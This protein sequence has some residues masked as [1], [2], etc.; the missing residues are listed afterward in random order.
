MNVSFCK[1]R[2]GA[3]LS[4][5]T[6]L[7]KFAVLVLVFVSAV[8]SLYAETTLKW[9][10]YSQDERISSY[11]WQLG[12]EEDG[13]W[14]VVDSSVTTLILASPESDVLYVQASY[15][16][17]NWSLSS[18][19]SHSEVKSGQSFSLR[20]SLSPYSLAL[21]R[22]YNGYGTSSS[23]TKTDSVYGLSS[24]FEFDWAPTSWLT[25]YPE[26]G[27]DLAVK[28]EAVIPGG[29]TV[30]YFKAGAGADFT[31]SI[32]GKS[33]LLAGFFGGAMFHLSAE[34]LSLTPYFGARLGYGY[35]VSEHFSLGAMSRVSFA[36]FTGQRDRL[37]N[38]M[39]VLIDPVS[40]TLAYRF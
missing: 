35:A 38:S 18:S 36:L 32:S 29:K 37:M 15:D 24:S 8:F 27:Y 3:D 11:R 19:A 30:H 5:R 6:T 1:R 40:V 26:I 4:Y 14:T 39:T 7:R 12:G 28:K 21:Y 23:R 17:V 34:K 20:A 2:G 16:G 22:F 25:L 33:S 13:K 10:W 9:S 31:F